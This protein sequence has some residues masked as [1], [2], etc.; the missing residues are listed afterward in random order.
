MRGSNVEVEKFVNYLASSDDLKFS[1]TALKRFKKEPDIRHIVEGFQTYDEST[2]KLP[3]SRRGIKLSSKEQK[4]A[5]KLG[6]SKNT[7]I[8]EIIKEKYEIFKA[9]K[10]IMKHTINPMLSDFKRF[11]SKKLERKLEYKYANTKDRR[12]IS[13][14]EGLK[15]S[16]YNR[17]SKIGKVIRNKGLVEYR[18]YNNDAVRF[19]Y[20]SE[21]TQKLLKSIETA[22]KMK[23]GEKPP[24]PPLVVEAIYKVYYE[25]EDTGISVRI[26]DKEGKKILNII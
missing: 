26:S 19:I 24:S 12:Q 18:K 9:N 3:P 10:D 11:S 4:I 14:K 16:S 5:E 2:S 22:Y 8:D 15:T 25:N 23:H 13:I 6:I 17:N 20:D 21:A 1:K 7:M